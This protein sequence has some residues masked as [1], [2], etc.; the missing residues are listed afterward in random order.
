[1]KKIIAL[2]LVVCALA[3]CFAGCGAKD[4]RGEV[5]SNETAETTE[6]ADTTETANDNTDETQ[7]NETEDAQTEVTDE[8][9]EDTAAEDEAV[10]LGTNDGTKY[11]NAFLGIGFRADGWIFSTDE[12]IAQQNGLTMDLLDEDTA[13]IF[14]NASVVTDMVA[15]SEDGTQNVNIT[16]EKA[17]AALNILATEQLYAENSVDALKSALEGMGA[18]NLD[19]KIGEAQIGSDTHPTLE[20]SYDYMG[21]ELYQK[22]VILKK[23]SY[24]ASITV[25]SVYED[26]TDALVDMFY[27]L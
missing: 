27:T 26:S 22:A 2:L 15:Q 25:T 1:M 24:F 17:S 16:I 9:A 7:T 8:T 23:G 6:T 12:E 14:E 21:A 5:T 18:E 20:I 13:K 3:V 4:V 10:E 19:I 11:E